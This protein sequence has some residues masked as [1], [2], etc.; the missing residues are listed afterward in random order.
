MS[1]VAVDW[2]STNLRAYRLN[3]QLELEDRIDAALGIKN[4]EHTNYEKILESLLGDWLVGT[5]YFIFSGMITSRQGWIETPY[6]ACPVSLESLVEQIQAQ[7][8]ESGHTAYFMPGVCCYLFNGESSAD[9][10][11][12]EEVQL[13]GMS[14]NTRKIVVLPGTHSKWVQLNSHSIDTFCTYM[15]G[16]L[17]ELVRYQS[18]AGQLATTTDHIDEHFLDGVNIGYNSDQLM[19]KLF[20]AR[21]S[22]LL[23]HRAPEAVHSYLSGLLIGTEIRQGVA[24]T[25]Q[26]YRQTPIELV[27][28]NVLVQRYKQAFDALSLNAVINDTTAELNTY[29]NIAGILNA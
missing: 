7:K 4:I 23:G 28:S 1:V 19:G 14:A 3:A 25:P 6:V 17:F 29:S 21:S 11:R 15:T 27:G 9:V 18:L 20:G 8:L 22:V 16:E 12:G 13:L 24:Q 26:G 2:G 5:Q 10:M